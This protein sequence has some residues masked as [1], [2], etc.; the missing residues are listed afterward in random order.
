MLRSYTL[1]S[2]Q[3]TTSKLKNGT[4]TLKEIQKQ[5]N[6]TKLAVLARQSTV[7]LITM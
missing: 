5:G 7:L 3:A 1:K 4:K 2:I 6:G